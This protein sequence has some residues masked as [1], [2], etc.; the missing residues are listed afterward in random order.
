MKDWNRPKPGVG[1]FKVEHVSSFGYVVVDRD[2]RHVTGFTKSHEQA[3]SWRDDKQRAAD[4]QAKRGPRPCLRCG[5]TFESQGIH[6]RMC[7]PCRGQRDSL[8]EEQRPYI[9]AGRRSA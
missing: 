6:N 9:S 5:A 2:G 1:T 7:N 4:K 8:G 3:K